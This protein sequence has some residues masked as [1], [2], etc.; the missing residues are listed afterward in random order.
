MQGYPRIPTRADIG[1][2]LSQSNLAALLGNPHILDVLYN[3]NVKQNIYNRD[4]IVTLYCQVGVLG[5]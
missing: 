2:P 4:L 1:D 3:I 5:A